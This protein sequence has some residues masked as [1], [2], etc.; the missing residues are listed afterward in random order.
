MTRRWQKI[1]VVYRIFGGDGPD[2]DYSE[3]AA[4][5]AYRF[6]TDGVGGLGRGLFEDGPV[7][8][9]LVGKQWMDAQLKMWREGLREGTLFDWELH[10]SGVYPEW[11]LEKNFPGSTASYRL[12][13]RFEELTTPCS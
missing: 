3:A 6:E 9:Y 5:A 2:L 13:Q 1:A 8:G 7:N 4:D 10:E 12:H 11:W